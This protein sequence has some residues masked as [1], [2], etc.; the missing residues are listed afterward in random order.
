MHFGK[1]LIY[2]KRD[3]VK[4][5]NDNFYIKANKKPE[6]LVEH[7]EQA[8]MHKYLNQVEQDSIT[9]RIDETQFKAR[10]ANSFSPRTAYIFLKNLSFIRK[11]EEVLELHLASR[12][13]LT[14]SEETRLLWQAQS[15][16]GYADTQELK[17]I[18]SG[19]V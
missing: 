2:E 12:C 19:A 5:S 3:A 18:T 14:P 1:C 4:T 9:N 6:E 16:G 13:S 17:F 10:I 7:R 8:E 11:T 15:I